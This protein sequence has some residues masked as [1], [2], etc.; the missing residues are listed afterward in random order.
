MVGGGG[1][2]RLTM[3][4]VKIISCTFET[5]SHESPKI[6]DEMVVVVVVVGPWSW[7]GSYG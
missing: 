3:V 7:P 2:A 1:A 5:K 4:R 6:C